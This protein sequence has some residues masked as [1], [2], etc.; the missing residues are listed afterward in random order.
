MTITAKFASRCTC[1]CEIFPGMRVEW[2]KGSPARHVACAAEAAAKAA[3]STSPRTPGQ[4]SDKQIALLNRLASKLDRV[5]MF[6]S[7]SGSGADV[8][9]SI[10]S[11]MTK[12]LTA[13]KASELIDLALGSLS[14]EM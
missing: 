2:T 3:A 7:F 5:G 8:A 9:D 1:G 12:T 10:R 11:Q 6:D 14:D 13:R 4:A